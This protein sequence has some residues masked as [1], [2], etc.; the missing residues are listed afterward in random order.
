MKT[1]KDE[2]SIN[3]DIKFEDVVEIHTQ[4]PNTF[5]IPSDEEREK[6][7]VG[8]HI[9][10]MSKVERFWTEVIDIIKDD[11]GIKQYVCI[12]DN[13][14]VLNDEINVGSIVPVMPWNIMDIRTI[15]NNE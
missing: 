1:N 6:V 7:K 4:H 11:Q 9:K 10:V 13:I 14:L 15:E 8:Q 5:Y 2:D 12:V 3:Y